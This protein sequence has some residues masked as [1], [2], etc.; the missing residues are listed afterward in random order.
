MPLKNPKEMPKIPKTRQKKAENAI[1][2][3][4]EK[5]PDKIEYYCRFYFSYDKLL[6]KDFTSI[7]LE[8]TAEFT[9][10]SYEL[11]VEILQEKRDIY[12]VIMGLSAKM[13]AVPQIEPATKITNLEE[14]VGDYTINVVKQDGCINS[15]RVN[16]NRFSK[17]IKLNEEFL[18]EK[19]NNRLF[20]K[21]N[22]ANDLFSFSDN[23]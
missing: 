23:E 20:C 4:P 16:I 9:N 12:F 8:T 7:K 6:K 18:P 2:A 19:E 11:N 5:K 3:I 15:A 17:E 14:L 1:K 21:F 10:F 22:V 13:N